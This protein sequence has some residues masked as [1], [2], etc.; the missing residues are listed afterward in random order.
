M[1]VLNDP[2]I[3]LAPLPIYFSLSLLMRDATDS[4][5][6]PHPR[7][8]QIKN[9][10]N[11]DLPVGRSRDGMEINYDSGRKVRYGMSALFQHKIVRGCGCDL[12]AGAG[13]AKTSAAAAAAAASMQPIFVVFPLYLHE[14][15]CDGIDLSRF[16]AVFFRGGGGGGGGVRL[17]VPNRPAVQPLFA[18]LL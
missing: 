9:T 17:V 5:S 1:F 4:C 18:A 15:V 14:V 12:A 10:L 3:P 8:C 16:V 11:E 2:R 6:F 13:T 7:P